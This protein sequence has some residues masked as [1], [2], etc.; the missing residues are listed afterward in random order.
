MSNPLIKQSELLNWPALKTEHITPALDTLLERAGQTVQKVTA[1]ETPATWESVVEPLEE[2]LETLG[3]AWSAV[4]HLTGVMDSEELR[5]AYNANLPRMT[6]FYIELSQNEALFAK[7]KAIASSQ[8]FA[9]LDAP[10]A[11]SSRVKSAT[12]VSRAR[13]SRPSPRPASRRSARKTPR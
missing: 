5:G 7:Y 10:V 9:K 2:A 3:R 12:F 4:G 1:H 11:G 6:Q 8:E 13:N